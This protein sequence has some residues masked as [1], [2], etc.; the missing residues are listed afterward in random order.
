MFVP[1]AWHKGTSVEQITPLCLFPFDIVK[2]KELGME[3]M[4]NHFHPI[5]ISINITLCI[6]I[7]YF[8]GQLF[9]P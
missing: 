1:K 7:D 2:E 9:I 4:Q 5:D 3:E 6:P 8:S